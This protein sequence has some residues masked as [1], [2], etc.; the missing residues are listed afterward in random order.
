MGDKYTFGDGDRAAARLRRLAE[1]YEP[2]TRELLLRAERQGCALA[3]DLGCGPGWSTRLLHDVVRP[4]RAVGL[5]ASER[6]VAEARRLQPGALE[7]LRHDV[8]TSP[9]PVRPDLLLA[10]F[11]LTHL[12]E[13][14]QVLA[15]WAQASADGA[16]LLLHETETLTS[17][18][19]ALARYYALVAE[20]QGHYGQRFDVGA[21][22]DGALESSPW[23]VLDSRAV[24]LAMPAPHMAELHLANLRTWRQDEYAA[25][26]FDAGELEELEGTLARIVTGEE[27]AEAVTNVVRQVVAERPA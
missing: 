8:T 2:S 9:F 11:L 3:T 4:A 13:T 18:H 23:R 25:R 26:T 19:P 16:R 24:P 21:R 7:F 17:G 1:L 14:A 15:T 5:D 10:R 12:R 6:Y 22:L 27:R 20:L